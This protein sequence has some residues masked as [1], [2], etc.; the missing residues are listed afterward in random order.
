MVALALMLG[1]VQEARAAQGGDPLVSTQRVY[2]PTLGGTGGGQF[3]AP[4]PEVRRPDGTSAQQ[5]LTGFELRVADD[6][7][8]IR[9]VCVTP[10]GPSSTSPVELQATAG[11][12]LG[13]TLYTVDDP[14][15]RRGW[16][17]GSGG[18]VV[19]LLCPRS[20]P[21]VLG[22]YVGA[23]GVDHI[24]VNN[25]YLYCGLAVAT[26][27]APDALPSAVVDAP[28]YRPSSGF[29]GLGVLR[30]YGEH[31]WGGQACP[32]GQVAIGLHGRSGVWLDSIGLICGAPSR[33]TASSIGRIGPPSA[34]RPP[35]PICVAARDARA[36]QSPAAAN[37]EAQ[38][39]RIERQNDAARAAKPPATS[40]GRVGG[41][42]RRSGPPPPICDAAQAARA[43]SSPAAPNLE[44]QCAALG[45]GAGP[46]PGASTVDELAVA[47]AAIAES[48]PAI[49]ELREQQ[50]NGPK[51]R[52]FD[53]GVGASAADTAWG[54]GKQRILESLGALEQEGFKVAAS[55]TLDRNRHAAL[56]AAGAAIAEGDG[57]LADGRLGEPDVRY[58]LG[59]DI[60][61]G[62][63][64]DP[65]LGAVG[66]TAVGPGSMGIRDGL[67]AP[68]RRGFDASMKLHL[69]RRY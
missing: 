18:R 17:G 20:T 2:L 69:S 35:V 5:V 61:T 21:S 42:S 30:E 8:A 50:S 44:A 66:N 16:F 14:A 62:L 65:A 57:L 28:G 4:C 27:Q 47:G 45:G 9:P 6:V 26:H 53:V 24:V 55:F 60:A 51:R 10:L 46:L 23:E 68:A 56:A 36:R 13:Q 49:A 29:L 22:I 67:S 41:A 59:Y 39:A 43:R 54:P 7:D 31:D 38:C 3:N 33:A 1:S 48:D 37:L 63:F 58:R 19:H 64:G 34:A 40:I 15:L 11:A 52:G 25:I 32:D 12:A